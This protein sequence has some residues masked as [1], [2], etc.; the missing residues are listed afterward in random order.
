MKAN[1]FV[2]YNPTK[3]YFGNK[4]LVHLPEEVKKYGDKAALVYGGGSIKRTGLYDKIMEVLGGAD[5][6]VSECAG[7]EPNPLYTS[8]N[9]AAKISREN[10]CN[11]IIAVGGGSVIDA[12]KVA[13][14]AIFMMATAGIL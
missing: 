1:N 4:Q 13:A 10:D 3:I 9:R 6:R 11:V 8:V 12:A 2:Y 7:I 5:I 14:Q